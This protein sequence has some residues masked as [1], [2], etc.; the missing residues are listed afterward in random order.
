[1]KSI[2]RKAHLLLGGN[3][4]YVRETFSKAEALLADS[5]Q[6]L[7]KSSFYESKPWGMESKNLFINQVWLVG[8]SIEPQAL[9]ERILAVE[10]ALGRERNGAS[11]E[12]HYSDRTLDIDIL[13]MEDLVLNSDKL[14]IP[15]PKLHL[16]AFTLQPLAE[17]D[18][19]MI[20]PVLGKS[21]DNLLENCTDNARASKLIGG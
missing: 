16:R 4:G 18:P 20:H 21:I 19:N 2:K 6:I 11:R 14:I 1:L 9:L 7:Q 10:T 17:V 5:F 13:F 12:G 8:I 3:L 15:H